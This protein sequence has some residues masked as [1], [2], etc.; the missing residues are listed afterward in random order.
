VIVGVNAFTV[1]EA[2]PIDLHRADP[3]VERR[4]LDRVQELRARRDP[5]RHAAAIGALQ[6]ACASTD[7]V[8]PHLIEAGKAGAT[9]GEMCDVFR[10]TFGVY[11]DPGRF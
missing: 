6:A 11:R 7:N 3:D 4:Q 10:E 1:D 9:L 2:P 5:A 8:M